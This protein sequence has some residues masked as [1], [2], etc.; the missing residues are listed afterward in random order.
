MNIEGIILEVGSL[1][2]NRNSYK[3]RDVV[4]K[5]KG[6]YPQFYKIQ[7]DEK[8]AFLLDSYKKDDNINIGVNLRGN[9]WTN[10]KTN[11][12]MYFLNLIGWKVDKESQEVSATDHHKDREIN[13]ENDN[14]DLPF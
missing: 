9:K 6:D 3:T 10:P 13:K 7:F 5:T 1:K 14:D 4:V 12:D 11:E 2:A 8:K